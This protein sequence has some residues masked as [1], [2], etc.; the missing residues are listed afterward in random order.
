MTVFAHGV[1]DVCGG[2]AF[3]DVFIQ[4]IDLGHDEDVVGTE[5]AGDFRRHFAAGVEG[6]KRAVRLVHDQKA[7]RI[8]L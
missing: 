4:H 7:P 5:Y 2:N 6:G 3:V 1:D 8:F